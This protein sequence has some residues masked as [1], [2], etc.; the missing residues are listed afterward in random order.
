MNAERRRVLLLVPS[1]IHGGAQRVISTLLRHLDRERFE[2]HLA[3][4]EAK[5][6][7]L[8][9]VPD[10]VIVHDLKVGRVRYSLPSIVK[11][12]WK[13]RPRTVLSTLVYLN[14][15]LLLARPLLPRR[16]RVVVRE[17]TAP[18]AFLSQETRH[19]RLWEWMIRRLYRKADKVVCLSDT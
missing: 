11:L 2:V 16:T 9:D 18:A 14:L 5:G 10:D 13:V 8:A 3:L 19:P 6:V 12:V 1:L 15:A 7:Y 17:S 4:L